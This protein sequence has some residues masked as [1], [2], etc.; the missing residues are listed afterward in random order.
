MG[1]IACGNLGDTKK[2]F[3]TTAINFDTS[4]IK[5]AAAIDYQNSLLV[6]DDSIIVTTKLIHQKISVAES[7]SF[8]SQHKAELT[9]NKLNII[10][11]KKA[12]YKSIVN[13]L[14][15]MSSKTI[16]C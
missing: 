10:A 3:N 9:K 11:T 2:I 6:Y 4:G 16:L 13:V 7:N 12:S 5:K 1:L 15:L 14:N 8:V